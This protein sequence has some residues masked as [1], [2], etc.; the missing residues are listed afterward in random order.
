MWEDGEV[1]GDPQSAREQR[2]VDAFRVAQ[3]TALLAVLRDGSHQSPATLREQIAKGM[4]LRPVDALRTGR[5]GRRPRRDH[6]RQA[7]AGTAGIG[8]R[9]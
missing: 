7:I 6:A 5:Y 9:G 1:K 4:T 2:A 3:I 8:R